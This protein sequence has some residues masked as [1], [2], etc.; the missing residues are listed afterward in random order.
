ME[1]AHRFENQ[2]L[3]AFSS[4]AS[5]ILLPPAQARRRC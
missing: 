5:P 2:P 4:N 1:K 3:G